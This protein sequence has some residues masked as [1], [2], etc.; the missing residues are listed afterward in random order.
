MHHN[1][2]TVPRSCHSCRPD[3]AVA[4]QNLHILVQLDGDRGLS[5]G[6]SQPTRVQVVTR[7]SCAPPLS[8]VLAMA[9]LRFRLIPNEAPETWYCNS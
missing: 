2:A 7:P 9:V 3:G 4:A 1:F 6:L 5:L 8:L